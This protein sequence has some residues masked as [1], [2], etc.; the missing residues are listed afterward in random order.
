MEGLRIFLGLCDF[1]ITV[2][3][4]EPACFRQGSSA[5]RKASLLVDRHGKAIS[6][7]LKPKH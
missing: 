4:P 7:I 2:D 6:S 3:L 1:R 5:L